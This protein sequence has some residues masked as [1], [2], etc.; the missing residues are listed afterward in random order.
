VSLLKKH[1]VLLSTCLLWAC[2]AHAQSS[3]LSTGKWLKIPITK[4]GVYRVSQSQLKQAGID[5]AAID[6]RTIKIYGNPGGMLPQANMAT[7]P[8]DLIENA[9][10]VQGESD[11]VFNTADG[12][13]FYATH[14][15]R[16]Y[17][18]TNREVFFYEQNLYANENFYFLTFGGE[19]GKRVQAAPIVSATTL[20]TQF[21]SVTHHEL[22]N[23]NLLKSGREWLGEKFSGTSEVIVQVD[24]EGIVLGSTLKIVSDVVGSSTAPSSFALSINS[25]SVGTQMITPISSYRYGTKAF[26]NRDTFL[27][28]ANN[29]GAP[30][31][32][33][34][35][36]RY[37][38]TKSGSAGATGYLNFFT[39]TTTR[40]LAVYGAQTTFRSLQ[41]LQQAVSLFSIEDVVASAQVWD[42]TDASNAVAHTLIVNGNT[43]T[44]SAVS[45]TL[46]EFV[47]F[48]EPLATGAL[49]NVNNQNLRNI[50]AVNLLIVTD[51][52]LK[53]EAQRL[54]NHRA[55]YSNLSAVVVTVEQI[56]NEFS[57]G[58]ADVTAIRD[59]TRHLKQKYPSQFKHLL[60][61]G[62]GTYDYKN[63]ISGNVNHVL[64][65]E[66]RNSTEP[67][68]TFSSDDYFGLLE[69]NEGEWTECSSCN[70]TLDIGV[71]R[72]PIKTT[73]QAVDVVDKIIAYETDKSKIGSWQT[74]VAFV[75][76]D[77]NADDGFN[78]I[79]QKQ[80]DLLSI[81]IE[82]APET[83]FNADKIFMGS[84]P[85]INRPSGQIAPQVNA[86]I[87]SKL[88]EGALIIN[89]TGHG[90]EY[91]WADERILDELLVTT[92]ENSR[93]P[94]LVTAT[95]EFGRHDDPTITSVAEIVLLRKQYGAIGLVT[96]ARPVNSSTNFNLNQAFYDA[97]LTK[98]D[99]KFQT[100]GAVFAQTKN[101][102][103]SGV[104]NRNFSLLGDPSM[105]LAFPEQQIE[106][107]AI[108]T[109]EFT[110]TLRALATVTV[111]GSVKNEFVDV[112]TNFNGTVEVTAF[113]KATTFKTSGNE[114]VPFSYKQWSN[115]L[116]KGQARV[117]N[118][119]FEFSFIM[120]KNIAYAIGEGRMNL[121][122]Q[123]ETKTAAGVATIKVGGS[124]SVFE[125][126]ITAP[127]LRAFMNDTTFINGG[128]VSADASLVVRLADASGIT[129]SSF[130]IGNDLQG[131]LDDIET[132]ELNE[133]YTADAN[134]FRKG[135]VTF[136]L[137]N[138]APGS[139]FITVKAW[140]THNNPATARV[141]FFVT[142]GKTLIIEEF[143]NYPNP[144]QTES[145]LFFTH[146]TAGSDLHTEVILYSPQGEVITQITDSVA[147]S[148]YQVNVL[149]FKRKDLPS[150]L[151]LAHLFVRSLSTGKQAR[152][153][154]KLIIVN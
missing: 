21:E 120:P 145:S 57:S 65:Y 14:A 39:I 75:A 32:T 79:H 137:R 123:S 146:N 26:H 108:Q 90:N 80:A 3:V 72:I 54:A 110:D 61:F 104:A 36:I 37:D 6:P 22:T 109:N 23:F 118:G 18:D 4:T 107:G 141:D 67:L 125:T 96:T 148:P 59:F 133:Y 121:F 100:L 47:V 24:I 153:T 85:K 119:F 86:A 51:D 126:D 63:T 87:E 31:R 82:T 45:S 1:I 64:T 73:A 7:R 10:I 97:L 11:G 68:A 95:C 144:F 135:T 105:T 149:D 94:F 69:E 136:P 15:D 20:V 5:V 17:L 25:A 76:D 12:I 131:V 60:L 98:T 116:F 74:N 43:G 38:Y 151:Y 77:G 143:G 88:E 113:D 139:H 71:G 13:L 112:D 115:V 132:F 49:V 92:A 16:S 40:K 142:D 42:V 152:A 62:R 8:L 111:S 138:L 102:S 127:T 78:T 129:I 29:V 103:A 53:S 83:I 122:A 66:S 19:L 114:S 140:D 41:S 89:Y 150:G 46:K 56:F 128:S 106:V 50:S 99:G 55:A 124:S 35:L 84:Y 28:A 2:V 30:N 101:N 134:N 147:N 81:Q 130:G 34:Q 9:I 27:I 154:A 48:N 33:E 58:R 44:F 91:V 52:E 93:L 117:Q 70:E